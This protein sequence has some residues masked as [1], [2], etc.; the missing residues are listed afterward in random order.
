MEIK[1]KIWL[2]LTKFIEQILLIILI[3]LYIVIKKKRRKRMDRKEMEIILKNS[4]KGK[5]IL[6]YIIQLEK[7]VSNNKGE[8]KDERKDY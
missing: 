3:W 4:Y 5:E 7:Q 6:K 2:V 8:F 1:E